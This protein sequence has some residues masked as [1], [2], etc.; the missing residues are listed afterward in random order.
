M[1]TTWAWKHLPKCDFYLQPRRPSQILHVFNVSLKARGKERSSRNGTFGSLVKREVVKKIL[2]SKCFQSSPTLPGYT[3]K[4]RYQGIFPATVLPGSV[5]ELMGLKWPQWNQTGEEWELADSHWL[6]REEMNKKKTSDK[7]RG[8]K[9]KEKEEDPTSVSWVKD[10]SGRGRGKD[11][12]R[13][14][15]MCEGGEGAGDRGEVM[16]WWWN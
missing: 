10:S 1:K 7:E 14:Y 13:S 12:G 9:G 11:F 5:T 16:L 2:T 8:G 4:G 15:G 3:L 6:D